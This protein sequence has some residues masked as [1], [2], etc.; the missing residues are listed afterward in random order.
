MDMGWSIEKPKTTT[1][2]TKATTEFPELTS[3]VARMKDPFMDATEITNCYAY[4][5]LEEL[6]NRCEQR[7]THEKLAEIS[8]G[9]AA[10]IL[11]PTAILSTIGNGILIIFLLFYIRLPRR[12]ELWGIVIAITDISFLFLTGVADAGTLLGAPWWGDSWIPVVY[13]SQSACKFMWTGKWFLLAF[14][15]NLLLF[16]TLQTVRKNRADD[17]R[18]EWVFRTCILIFIAA[19]MAVFQAMPAFITYGLWQHHGVFSC[20]P[21]PIL[22]SKYH[23]FFAVHKTVFVDGIFQCICCVL[24]SGLIYRQHKRT[25]CIVNHLRSVQLS[26]DTISVALVATFLRLDESCQNRRIVLSILLPMLFAR[27]ARL[28]FPDPNALHSDYMHTT[29]RQARLRQL[30]DI[31]LWHLVTYI[32]VFISGFGY[33][34]WYMNVPAISNALHT[35]CKKLWFLMR[36]KR[37]SRFTRISKPTYFRKSC[38]AVGVRPMELN[39]NRS[40]LNLLRYLKQHLQSFYEKELLEADRLLRQNSCHFE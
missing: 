2:T 9:F 26:R 4:L 29:A 3:E 8:A 28:F 16:V 39:R 22:P 27:V 32:E 38:A 11:V 1:I 19:I 36:H 13:Q 34:G 14:R 40:V 17:K 31:S 30:T 5:S 10:V 20:S 21:D 15:A 35:W 6:F 33:L 25:R 37:R 24:L 12:M 7:S 18:V 23:R